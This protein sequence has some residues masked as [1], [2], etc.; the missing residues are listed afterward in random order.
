MKYIVFSDSHGRRSYMEK[1]LEKE[2]FDGIIFCGD[3]LADAEHIEHLYPRKAFIKVAGNCDY[4][5]TAP[6]EQM[7]MTDGVYFLVCHGHRYNVKY[8]QYDIRRHARECNV[9]AIL[10]GHSHTQLMETDKDGILLLNPGTAQRG[11]YALIE[12][13]NGKVTAKLKET[14]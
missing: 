3:G 5:G 7:A 1:A 8:T 10:F 4:S 11:E 6:A 13:K 12:F 14:D 9:K 2:S